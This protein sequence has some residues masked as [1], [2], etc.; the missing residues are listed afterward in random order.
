MA[1]KRVFVSEKPSV[2]R[3]FA[4]ALGEDFRRFDGYLESDNSVV[5]WCV[6]HLVTMSYPEVYDEKY[7]K[8]SMSTLPFIPERFRYEVIDSV[9]KQYQVVKRI[10]TSADTDTIY[11]CT[12]SG[13]EGEYIYRLIASEAGVKDKRQLR[14]WIDSQTREEILRGIREA[15]ADSEYDNLAASAYLRAKEDYLMGINFSRAMTLKYGDRMRDFLGEKRCVIA[16]GRVMTCVLGIVVSREREIRDFVKTSFYRVIAAAE[17]GAEFEWTC[18]EDSRYNGSPL[19]YSE[20][21]FRRGEDAAALI[22]SLQDNGYGS[23]LVIENV[24]RK[25]ETRR[26]PLLYNLAELQNDC[27][28]LFKISPD[29]TLA[30]AQELYEKKLTTYPRTDAR[31]LS[32]AVAK[33]IG[34][35]LRGIS[36]I[37]MFAPY[38]SAIAEAGS[39]AGIGKTRYTDDKAITDHYAIIPTGD[40]VQALGSLSPT[41]AKV[42]EIIVRRFLAVFYPP[43]VFDRIQVTAAA[44]IPDSGIGGS[45]ASVERFNAGERACREEGYLAVMKYSF[46]RQSAGPGSDADPQEEETAAAGI[47]RGLRK[48]EKLALRGYEIREGET[49]PPKRYNSGSLIL[50]ME[51]AGQF[52]EEEDL[53]E[54]I[55]G[56]GIGTSATRAEILSK[57]VR[58]SYLSLNHKTQIITPTR[59]GEMIYDA[60]SACIKPLLDPRLTASWEMGLQRVV[61]GSVSE[62]E[63]MEKLT[64]FITRRCDYVKQTDFNAAL[65]ANYRR[66]AEVYPARQQKQPAARRTAKTGS[67]G[68]SRSGSRKRASAGD[69]KGGIKNGN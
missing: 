21:G 62:A 44:K 2:A 3:E 58:N 63:Y 60:V 10:L 14:V 8:W 43:A 35:N 41:V 27:S 38:V 49:T 18:T 69:K 16:V 59:F 23:A 51:N 25:K 17:N 30:A 64:A 46:S 50:T 9:K 24:T 37:P 56:A 36:R 57:L 15:K 53:R 65:T 42:Y 1:K 12:D 32:S 66:I 7:K 6:G 33:Q 22:G 54:Q 47:L 48:G 28:R 67:G 40:G 39:A 61:E 4:A 11:I 68:A 13:R 5:T 45:H 19:L 52:I 20:K 34:V 55:R 31:V 29:Q 26:P